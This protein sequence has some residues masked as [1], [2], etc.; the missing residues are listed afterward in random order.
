M[1]IIKVEI[2]TEFIEELELDGWINLTILRQRD[3]KDR[4]HY[5]AAKESPKEAILN[6]PKEKE[7]KK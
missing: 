6:N 7:L 3:P 1:P 2:S 5:L 4:I